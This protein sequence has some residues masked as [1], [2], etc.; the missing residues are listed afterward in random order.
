M[1]HIYVPTF[2]NEEGAV[3]GPT[4]RSEEEAKQWLE[5]QFCNKENCCKYTKYYIEKYEA[6]YVSR[7][8]AQNCNGKAIT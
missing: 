5:S 6:K 3:E 1:R 7:E 8:E 2:G 4:C